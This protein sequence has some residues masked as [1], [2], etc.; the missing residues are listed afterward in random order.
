MVEVSKRGLTFYFEEADPA[1]C[2]FSVAYEGRGDIHLYLAHKNTGWEQAAA[3]GSS[4]Q[5]WTIWRK[6]DFEIE[7]NHDENTDVAELKQHAIKRMAIFF[8]LIL[9][10]ALIIF[11]SNFFTSML[12]DVLENGYLS[13]SILERFNVT[14]YPFI[15]L[16]ILN[17]ILRPWMYYFRLEGS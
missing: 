15:M 6:S 10:P 16:G 13:L 14:V 2:T 3:T 4:R 11:S 8:S 1:R 12:P 9:T 7:E 5:Q 17:M